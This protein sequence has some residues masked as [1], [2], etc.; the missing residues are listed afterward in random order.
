MFVYQV[1]PIDFWAGWHRPSDIFRVSDGRDDDG[2]YHSPTDWGPMWEK[3]QSLGTEAGWEGDIR[4]GPYV[5]VIPDGDG[6]GTC[7]VI[8]AWK[9]DNNGTTFIA[10]PY[11]LTWIEREAHATA[12]G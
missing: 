7:P 4:E 12:K 9:Q 5:T 8:I 2:Q 1:G 10:S 6:G 3:A 11:P